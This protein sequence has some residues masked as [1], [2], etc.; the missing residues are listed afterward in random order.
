LNYRGGIRSIIQLE[1]LRLIE[2]EMNGKLPIQCFFDMI[3]G[4]GWDCSAVKLWK[5]FGIIL[6]RHRSTGGLIALGLV[7]QNWT[8]E[9]CLHHFAQIYSKAL[10]HPNKRGIPVL[11]WIREKYNSKSD[12]T[13]FEAA[14][15]IAY[16]ENQNLFGDPRP[17]GRPGSHI[18][19]AVTATSSAGRTVLLAN[20]NRRTSK[21]RRWW[22]LY[23]S[24]HFTYFNWN[25]SVSLSPSRESGDGIEGLGSVR[26]PWTFRCLL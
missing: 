1:I 25:S 2:K 5:E 14:L 24:R 11:T 15:K 3:V 26:R 13:A 16:S 18:Q 9:D 4:T 19:V 20:Y 22:I 17:S 7:T 6:I 12:T 23:L 21:K 10:S 8:I